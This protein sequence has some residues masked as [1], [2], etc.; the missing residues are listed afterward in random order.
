M[1][2]TNPDGSMDA[3]LTQYTRRLGP[4]LKQYREWFKIDETCDPAVEGLDIVAAQLV[5]RDCML[6]VNDSG[7]D[8]TDFVGRAHELYDDAVELAPDPP[9]G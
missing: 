2:V 5:M 9:S 7:L 1:T 8:V 3:V 6:F 4:L